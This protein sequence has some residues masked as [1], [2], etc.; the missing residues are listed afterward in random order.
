MAREPVLLDNLASER[1]IAIQT[2]KILAILPP[3]PS[4]LDHLSGDVCE[5]KAK[6]SAKSLR[7]SLAQPNSVVVSDSEGR[8]G[9]SV[10]KV[11][12]CL[13]SAVRC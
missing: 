13:R 2:T 5:G 7:V 3:T 1:W 10:W 6:N 4:Q 8:T 12:N 9:F 11:S